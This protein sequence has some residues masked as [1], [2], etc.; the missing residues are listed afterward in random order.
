[1][2]STREHGNS[3]V[4]APPLALATGRSSAAAKFLTRWEPS[5]N[6]LN[7]LEPTQ[8]LYLSL[9]VL[10]WLPL[11]RRFPA[12]TWASLASATDQVANL[13]SSNHNSILDSHA[14]S[15]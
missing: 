7:P 4:L 2:V 8:P 6:P 9:R 10:R 3:W 12:D 13:A 5:G 11:T 1:M 14:F 15:I